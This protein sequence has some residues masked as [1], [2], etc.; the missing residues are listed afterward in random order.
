L[1][2][3][4]FNGDA[5][6]DLAVGVP[7]ENV[8]TVMLAGAVNILFGA[9]AG[10]HSAG[11]QIWTQNSAGIADSAEFGDR[12]GASLAAGDI[13]LDGKDD[14]A[15]GVP[16]E[17]V[18]AIAK[19]GAVQVIYSLPT[20]SAGLTFVGNQLWTQNSYGIADQAETNDAFGTTVALADLSGDGRADLVVGVPHESFGIKTNAGAVQVIFANAAGRLNAAWN[21]F[22][23]QDSQ[24]IAGTPTNKQNFGA[25]LAVGDF[26]GDGHADLVIGAPGDI[27]LVGAVHVLYGSKKRLT[28]LNAQ[29][30]TQEDL[31]VFPSPSELFGFSLAGGSSLSRS[32]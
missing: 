1:C 18:G 21:Q 27:G 23:T 6:D 31:G 14:L 13:N 17:G 4:N 11:A 15:I 5:Y 26:N 7:N 10:L 22:W 29:Y 24:G 2:V 9:N 8:G 12:F 28:S 25:A 19:A 32:A 30:W 20:G 3:G 16:G